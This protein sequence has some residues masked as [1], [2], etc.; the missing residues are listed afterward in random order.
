[1]T[2]RG[3]QAPIALRLALTFVAMALLA[4]AIVLVLAFAL[5]GRDIN[6]MVQDRREDLTASLRAT[7]AATYNSGAPGWTDA[8][9]RP[10]LDLAAR[11][12]TN[13]AVLGADGQ[14]V[15]STVTDPSTLSGAQR[16]PIM[17]GDQQVGTLVVSFDGR[18]L[19]ASADRLRASLNRAF[20][21]AAGLAALLALIVALFL[22]RRLTL[23]ISRLTA[24]AR[25]M[26]RGDRTTR[27]GRVPHAPREL[28]ELSVA[29][30]GMADA[31]DQQEMLR[32]GLVSDVAHELRTPVA[33]LQA[34]C[35]ALLD[36]V[37]PHT[38]EQTASLHEEVVRLAGL[39]EDLQ[40]LAS[41]DAAALA[42]HPLPCDLAVLVDASLDAMAAN[43]A[44]SQ[45]AVTR[46]LDTAWVN[47]DPVR[48]HQAIT[49]VLTNAQ[50]F[51]PAGGRVDVELTTAS[52]AAYLRI[53]DN[54]IGIPEQDRPHVFERFWR[55]RNSDRASGSGIGL[56]VVAELVAA[57]GGSIEIEQSAPSGT[58]MVLA[59][60]LVAMP[61]SSH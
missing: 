7:A 61:V 24:A 39:V 46:H 3:G 6:A 13:V 57:H 30:D 53:A 28:D 58:T 19:V 51:T 22:A 25:S 33:I 59:F 55:G 9:L 29:F 36:G 48:L 43:F 11:S 27:I 45:L 12:G 18:G 31:L 23:P 1:M 44:A 40:S 34:N 2:S 54:G 35:E 21:G 16:S 20:V 42:L 50:K 47:G 10:A 52:G 26:S 32:R 15:A 37:V 56:A 8:D 60:P 5:G 49:N 17:V 14:I 4:V 41:A 38:A